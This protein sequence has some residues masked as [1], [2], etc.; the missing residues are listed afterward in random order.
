MAVCE[1]KKLS[2]AAH[3]GDLDKIINDLI[4]LGAV[5]IFPCDEKL[6]DAEWD[7]IVSKIKTDEAES[8][9]EIDKQL[10]HL[11][12]VIDLLQDYDKTKKSIF[13][14]KSSR[15]YFTR[16]DMDLYGN[17]CAEVIDAAD[18]TNII[19]ERMSNLKDERNSLESLKAS[20]LPWINLNIP[21]AMS[22]TER[23]IITLG[24]ISSARDI[25]QIIKNLNR[26]ADISMDATVVSSDDRLTYIAMIYHA[27]DK[28]LIDANLQ[29][30]GISCVAF[31]DINMTAKEKIAETDAKIHEVDS[32]L[33]EEKARA[34]KL[35][36][37]LPAIKKQ[38]DVILS[39][40]SAIQ[41]KQKFLRTEC[42]AI[43][44]GCMPADKAY[45]LKEIAA[46]YS[47]FLEMQD[48]GSDAG[49]KYTEFFGK[50]YKKGGKAFAPVEL[51]L[52]YNS[53]LAE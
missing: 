16:E 26:A 17:D 12:S 23:S 13:G 42:A 27:D 40:R 48:Y 6:A 7:R 20:L 30:C 18:E 8:L 37:N 44:E 9:D 34:E 14:K 32:K 36:K 24:T 35:A 41:T 51:N 29:S 47:C 50:I 28:A 22:S 5:E 3:I 1:M 38:Y 4:W 10:T 2:L 19:I 53:V 33:E 31:D 49:V 39:R 52:K 25:F 45:R 15:Y 46:K 43:A 11:A 21:L